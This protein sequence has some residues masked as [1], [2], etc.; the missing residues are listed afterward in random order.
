MLQLPA[1]Y[2]EEDVVLSRCSGIPFCHQR[3]KVEGN[4][5]TA[6]ALESALVK[7]L[8]ILRRSIQAT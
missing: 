2:P 6:P 8:R 3:A 1:S 7:K 5:E 4:E